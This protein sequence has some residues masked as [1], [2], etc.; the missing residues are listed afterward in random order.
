MPYVKVQLLRD[1]PYGIELSTI[2]Q[3]LATAGLEYE[4]AAFGGSALLQRLT[5]AARRI[6]MHVGNVLAW[7]WRW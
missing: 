3:R 2:K 6:K 4:P 1:N 5:K 7:R